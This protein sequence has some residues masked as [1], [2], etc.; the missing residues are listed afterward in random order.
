MNGYMVSYNGWRFDCAFPEPNKQ[1]K[2]LASEYVEK[3][4]EDAYK[5]Y[6]INELENVH[7]N[8]WD[9]YSGGTESYFDTL[10]ECMDFINNLPQPKDK[11]EVTVYTI[12]SVIPDED[13]DEPD[14]EHLMEGVGK[15]G[16]E[17]RMI[18]KLKQ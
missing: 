14:F 17:V 6:W 2:I 7:E 12:Y 11:Y 18:D 8:G 5:K 9:V 3:Y 16:R 1:D 13:D 10:S 4:G 15:A